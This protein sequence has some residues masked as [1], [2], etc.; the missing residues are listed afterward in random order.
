LS[1]IV[2]SDM[3]L[4]SINIRNQLI[5]LFGFRK[6]R[7]ETEF[8]GN[9]IYRSSGI[10]LVSCRRELVNSEHIEVLN[11]DLFVF[12]SRHSSAAGKPALLVHCTGNWTIEAEFGG[13]PYELAVAPA[14]AMREALRELAKQK[15]ELGLHKYEVTMECTHHGPTSM[16]TPLV[17]VELGSDKEHWVDQ[18]GAEAVARTV[19]KI[20]QGTKTAKTA[21]GI[22]GPHYAP[23]FTKTVL[24]ESSDIAVGHI[25]PSYVFQG[26]RKE[27]VKKAVERTL[28]RVELALLDWKGLRGENREFIKPILDELGLETLRTYEITRSS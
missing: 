9:P 23:N 20:A 19:Y 8:D 3:D 24:S 12:A 27:M 25:I 6:E 17:F 1:I 13:K 10:R 26:L 7:D 4:A 16:S 15:K 21:L 5:K 11:A 18:A 28:E 14:S 2:T 22:G